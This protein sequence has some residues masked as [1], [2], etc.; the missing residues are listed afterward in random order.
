M[1]VILVIGNGFPDVATRAFLKKLQI[2][3]ELDVLA[4]VDPDPFGI[5]ILFTYAF[6]S[7]NMSFDNLGLAV[8]SIQWV[9]ITP[10]ELV[11]EGV[12]DSCISQLTPDDIQLL[13]FLKKQKHLMY[14]IP[15]SWRK[16]IVE[17]M[18]Y[19]VKT[20]LESLWSIGLRYAGDIFI[21]RKLS[22]EGICYYCYSKIS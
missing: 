20:S 2:A 15:D 11:A 5:K 9:R 4:I 17:M 3:T 10:P 8:P 18:N 1:S 16:D 7:V 12:S 22:E 21:P 13:E 19:G 14:L 6:G